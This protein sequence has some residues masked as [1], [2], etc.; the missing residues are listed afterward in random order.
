MP[1]MRRQLLWIAPDPPEDAL[2]RALPD[3]WRVDHRAG[4]A[5]EPGDLAEA[6]FAVVAAV[7]GQ[8][9]GLDELLDHLRAAGILPVVLGNGHAAAAAQA[10]Q[11]AQTDLPVL[12]LAHDAP[13]GEILATLRAASAVRPALRRLRTDLD[14]ARHMSSQ[15]AKALEDV[16]EEMRLAGRLQRDFL[17]R[18][19]PRVGP[20]RF[21]VLFRPASW[22]SGD[23]YDVTRLD[24]THVGFYVADATGHGM[25]AALLTMF[26]K[27]ALQTKRITGNTY[28]IV[29]PEDSLAQ[30]NDDICEQEL[31]S[32]DFCTAVYGV[33]DTAALTLT[34]ARAGH[35]RPL[36]IH[37]NGECQLLDAEGRLLGVLPNQTYQPTCIRLAAG[38]RLIAY[39][40]GAEEIL[41]HNPAGDPVP[42]TEIAPPWAPMSQDDLLAHLAGCIDARPPGRRFDDDITL[43]VVDVAP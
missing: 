24:E 2:R 38:D 26:I 39:S 12:R 37:P 25:P 32:C 22:V 6:D 17:P 42:L 43:L 14:H 3:G 7:N 23:M 33:I 30:L 41:C 27:K 9:A 5:L 16:D 10:A 20:I 31:S 36:L 4:A 15:G 1:A 28:E 11:T 19:L 35:P 13:L 29:P 34:F 8:A 40:D 18:S 21:G